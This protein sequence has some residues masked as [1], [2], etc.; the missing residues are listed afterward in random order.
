[1]EDM[2][3]SVGAVRGLESSQKA[4]EATGLKGATSLHH[5][6]LHL[7][8]FREFPRLRAHALPMRPDVESAKSAAPGIDGVRM[9]R[10][11]VVLMMRWGFNL[12]HL[13]LSSFTG[14]NS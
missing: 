1:M 7:Q 10:D 8:V 11:L 9:R 14:E 12:S 13:R 4:R 6:G 2:Y 3:A 5:V